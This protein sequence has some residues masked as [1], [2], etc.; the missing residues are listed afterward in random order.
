VFVK[1]FLQ[2]EGTPVGLF[3]RTS[4]AGLGHFTACSGS[5]RRNVLTLKYYCTILFLD[6]DEIGSRD[7][8]VSIVTRL[9]GSI[10][11]RGFGIINKRF[12]C[13]NYKN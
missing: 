1:N 12:I 2:T 11:S 3:T 8:S 13:S 9:Q 6:P 5:K 4:H 10:P 7:S